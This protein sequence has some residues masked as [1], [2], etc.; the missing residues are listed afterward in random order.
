MWLI[1]IIRDD[2]EPSPMTVDVVG[3]FDSH[4]DALRHVNQRHTDGFT[5]VIKPLIKP[6][7]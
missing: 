2:C 3:P 5:Y 1:V 4:E 7:T 6:E